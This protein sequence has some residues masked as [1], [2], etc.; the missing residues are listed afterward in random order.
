MKRFT[1]EYILYLIDKNREEFITDLE[2]S[3]CLDCYNMVKGLNLNENDVELQ[4]S[5]CNLCKKTKSC[6][7]VI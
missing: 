6:I 5:V 3:M 7:K 4:D 1:E 2:S